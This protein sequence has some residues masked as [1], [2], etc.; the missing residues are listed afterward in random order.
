VS[1]GAKH[2]TKQIGV[3]AKD[4]T[5]EPIYACSCGAL[6]YGDAELSEHADRFLVAKT[7]DETES[8]TDRF[9]KARAETEDE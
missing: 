5:P 9:E 2:V 8:V 4:A 6:L 1:T 7:T 3:L